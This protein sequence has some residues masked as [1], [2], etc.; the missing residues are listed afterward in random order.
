[1]NHSVIDACLLLLPQWQMKTASKE[2]RLGTNTS[3]SSP[4]STCHNFQFVR[5]RSRPTTAFTVA[6]RRGSVTGL[7]SDSEAA[8]NY[9]DD[10]CSSLKRLYSSQYTQ[11]LLF[12]TQLLQFTSL[13]N[14]SLWTRDFGGPVPP[15]ALESPLWS[16]GWSSRP[17]WFSGISSEVVKGQ[18]CQNLNLL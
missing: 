13:I 7:F 2:W 16:R 1:M 3:T 15:T 8:T 4:T 12:S 14:L 17:K 9:V 5:A 18:L 10:K 6:T 11:T